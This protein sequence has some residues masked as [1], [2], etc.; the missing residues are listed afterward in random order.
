MGPQLN[1]ATAAFLIA[2]SALVAML[3]TE[4]R[5]A[6]SSY[7]SGMGIRMAA[8]ERREYRFSGA[9]CRQA[10]PLANAVLVVR[11]GQWSAIRRGN[12]IATGADSSFSARSGLPFP[13]AARDLPTDAVLK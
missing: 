8:F 2:D 7:L 9:C 3:M 13:V 5:L 1:I 11:M 12:S 6:P 4:H 10:K